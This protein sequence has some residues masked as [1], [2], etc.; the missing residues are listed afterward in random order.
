MTTRFP[1]LHAA[2]VQH[3]WAIMP[4]R[5][6]AI[7]EVVERRAEGIRLTSGEIADI[8]GHRQPNGVL[9]HIS[10]ET[11]QPIAADARV[12]GVSPSAL[13]IAVI[14]V[15]GIIAQHASQVDDISGPGGTSTERVTKSFRAARNDP[16]VKAIVLHVD[17][18]GGNVHGVQALFNEILSARGE[19]PIV[20]QVNS[21]A[22]SAAYWIACACDEIVITPGGQVGSIGVYALHKDVSKA[23]EEMGFKF[24]FVSAG[25]FKVEGNQFEPLSDE[26]HRALQDQID[27]YYAD[28]TGDVATGR[29]AK[30]ADVVNGF[31][32]G[33]V[34][35]DRQAVKLGMADR[36][37]T[38][39]E[40]LRRLA[41][42]KRPSG[43]KALSVA[44]VERPANA[45]ALTI[46]NIEVDGAQSC[47]IVGE[48]P[49]VIM[50]AMELVE[51]SGGSGMVFVDSEAGTI[52]FTAS[53]GTATYSVEGVTDLGEF[54]CRLL[55]SSVEPEASAEERQKAA[56]RDAF[57]RRRHAHRNRS[58]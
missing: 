19:K 12:D 40:T 24:T 20:A 42:A 36:V 2:I 31:G 32:E 56:D 4:D 55:S 43:T 14:S 41:T 46:K 18:P 7:A 9:A 38:M 22:A 57:R 23:A 3:P 28:F 6:E 29:N 53:N 58:A 25:K 16:S 47:A 49:S 48:V 34:E 1:H 52:A 5:L 21:L 27:A 50:V 35:K 54:V 37:A 33:R 13:V 15:M 44:T 11:L 45:Q 10:A 17:S 8:K 30:Q 26:A 51:S 39:D